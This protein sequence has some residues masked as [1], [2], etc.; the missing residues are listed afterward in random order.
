MPA[1]RAGADASC[2]NGYTLILLSAEACLMIGCLVPHD[3]PLIKIAAS[4]VELRVIIWIWKF[5]VGRTQ[6]VKVEGQLPKEV[7]VKSGVSQG[8][9]LGPL[10][11]L[12]Y[13]SVIWKNSGSAI[14]LFADGCLIYR[15]TV[16]N[17]DV[18]MLQICAEWGS[19][20]WKIG[21]K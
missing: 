8:S 2:R 21:R 11:F 16:N 14:R 13:I 3:R 4:G 6:R 15:E 19:G 9:V 10:L 20:L 5:L 17:Y 18:E 12:A 1:T 7:R